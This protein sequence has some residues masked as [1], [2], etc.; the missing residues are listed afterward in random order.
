MT[1]RSDPSLG[2]E[3]GKGRLWGLATLHTFDGWA[4]GIRRRV[5]NDKVRGEQ[6]PASEIANTPAHT[7]HLTSNSLELIGS[8]CEIKVISRYLI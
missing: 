6:G 7:E 1:F 8:Q 5:S 4:I 2:G 3:L